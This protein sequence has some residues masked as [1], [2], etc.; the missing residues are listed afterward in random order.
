M[1]SDKQ[2]LIDGLRELGAEV[3]AHANNFDMAARYCPTPWSENLTATGDTF[4]FI[5]HRIFDLLSQVEALFDGGGDRQQLG[6]PNV[7]KEERTICLFDIFD[8]CSGFEV[9]RIEIQHMAKSGGFQT[10]VSF[11]P[12]AGLSSGMFHGV[13]R[14]CSTGHRSQSKVSELP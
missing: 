11:D 2:Q 4:L 14:V 1:S 9:Q 7:S 6:A 3:E 13:L 5:G 8:L 12:F 10:V